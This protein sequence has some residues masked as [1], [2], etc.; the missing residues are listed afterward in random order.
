M[1]QP[2]IDIGPNLDLYWTTLDIGR[3]KNRLTYTPKISIAKHYF[4]AFDVVIKCIKDCFDQEGFKM[5]ALLE[6]VLLKAAK[7]GEY[8]EEFK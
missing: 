8:K 5:Y 7:H 1:S 3:A 2:F 4:E 6:Q